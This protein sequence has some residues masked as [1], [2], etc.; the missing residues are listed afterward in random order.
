MRIALPGW[1]LA[2]VT[3]CSAA[4]LGVGRGAEPAAAPSAAPQ[5][6]VSPMPAENS[7]PPTRQDAP[8]EL[9]DA[10]QPFKPE[11]PATE[12]ERA[13]VEALSLFA[14]GRMKEQHE[15]Y[16]GAL[17]MYERALRYDSNSLTLLRQ[18]V[19]VAF[20]LDRTSEAFRYAL[21][22][23]ELDAS[24][25]R[26]LQ[27]LAALLS[28]RQEFDKAL[29]SARASAC[30]AGRQAIGRLRRAV[31]GNRPARLSHRPAA[32]GGRRLRRGRRC[33]GTS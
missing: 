7:P 21:K 25:A 28:A 6:T 22:V 20:K 23:V 1:L 19:S 10:P 18:I 4:S 3:L 17:Q 31:D 29:E 13:R 32:R 24:D 5:G 11:R 26:M 15:D 30:A 8:L 9:E 14:A 2:C 27:Q 33:V 16:A 12:D